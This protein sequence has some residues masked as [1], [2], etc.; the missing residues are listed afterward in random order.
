MRSVPGYD[1]AGLDSVWR[2]HLV[3]VPATMGCN[4]GLMFDTEPTGTDPNGVPREGA[5]T[6]SHDGYRAKDFGPGGTNHFDAASGKR[7]HEVPRAYLRSATHEVGH[8]FNQIHQGDEGGV[9]NSI[10]SSTASRGHACWATEGTFPDGINLAFNETVTRHLRHYPDPARAPGRHGVL[11]RRPINAP[12]PADVDWVSTMR[13]EVATVDRPGP[14]G[15]ADHP[16]VDARQRERRPGGGAGPARHRVAHRSGQRH[17]LE[18][19]GSPSCARRPSTPAPRPTSSPWSPAPASRARPPCSGASR[20]RLRDA[21][22]A[23]GWRS[24]CCGG[25]PGHRWPPTGE[26]DV[27]VEYPVSDEDNEVAA[28]M[29]HPEVGRAVC[30]GDVTGFAAGAERVRSVLGT[31]GRATRPERFLAGARP[32][33]PSRRS[34]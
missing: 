15:P 33:W 31:G 8:A 24:S 19:D 30:A 27:F 16:G 20:L 9:D 28:L 4:R 10:M 14:A 29:L 13:L 2:V 34:P 22:A 3:V 32:R 21:R 18:R 12:Q 17:R 23:T 7:Q 5:A 26:T 25:W 1:P 6:F 11:Q